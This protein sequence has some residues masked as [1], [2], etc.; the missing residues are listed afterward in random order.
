MGSTALELKETD[1][2]IFWMFVN[3]LADKS[4]VSSLVAYCGLAP[5][6]GV[7]YLD[8]LCCGCFGASC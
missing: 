5:Y 3:C 6:M 1:P 2:V 7:V 8:G 4:C